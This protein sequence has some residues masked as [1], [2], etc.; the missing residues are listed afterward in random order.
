[1]ANGDY[2][3]RGRR[4]GLKSS[5]A[6]ENLERVLGLTQGMAQRAKSRK[7]ERG[8]ALQRD[9]A[10]IVGQNGKNYKRLID[11]GDIS[12]IKKQLESL[13]DKVKNS[14]VDT[15]GIYDF[16]LKDIDKHTLDVETYGND[17]REIEDLESQFATEVNRYVDNQSGYSKEHKEGLA[18][19]LDEK[20]KYYI[21]KKERFFNYYPD[22]VAKDPNLLTAMT[23]VEDYGNYIITDILHSDTNYIDKFEAEMFQVGLRDGNLKAL[24]TYEDKKNIGIATGAKSYQASIAQNISEGN[25]QKMLWDGLYSTPDAPIEEQISR[26]NE[27]PEDVK[28]HWETFDNFDTEYKEKGGNMSREDYFTYTKESRERAHK[29]YFD[30]AA[31]LNEEHIALTGNSFIHSLPGAEE[32][33]D[34]GAIR[35]APPA[36]ISNMVHEH[37][38]SSFQTNDYPMLKA[39]ISG[40]DI[41]GMKDLH[42]AVVSAYDSE[43]SPSRKNAIRGQWNK[44]YSGLN[45][46]VRQKGD[47]NF[48]DASSLF[49]TNINKIK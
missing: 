49:R 37:Y 19:E 27:A 30:A 39:I 14:D 16:Y 29:G 11:S 22:R 2:W 47:S 25:N 33:I 44:F 1:M 13:G 41:R 18:K 43:T 24:E 12:P 8:N 3:N 40:E 4:E 36:N 20:L 31:K 15:M 10:L 6:L 5:S 17:K 21:G 34:V 45:T 48:P 23:S 28:K 35:G 38:L 9:I 46:K 26:Y 42:D 32:A 7:E